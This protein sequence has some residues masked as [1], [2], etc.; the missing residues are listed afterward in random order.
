M[1]EAYDEFNIFCIQVQ[2]EKDLNILKVR[3][4]H[5]GKFENESFES[6]C[7]KQRIIHNKM[8]L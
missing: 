4:D 3:S 5:G 8:E 2:N 1:N 7:E 6:F